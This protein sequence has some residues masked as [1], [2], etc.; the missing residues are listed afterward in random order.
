MVH[1]SVPRP[2]QKVPLAI[3]DRIARPHITNSEGRM[4]VGF[5][6]R[7]MTDTVRVQIQ[8]DDD[9]LIDFEQPRTENLSLLCDTL[10]KF[11]E[12]VRGDESHSLELQTTRE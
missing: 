4:E 6:Y 9:S 7:S 5:Y 8:F 2:G 12:N 1:R 11:V 3:R 10:A